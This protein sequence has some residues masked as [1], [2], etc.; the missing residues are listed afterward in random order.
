MG[1]KLKSDILVRL[2]Y[3]NTTFDCLAMMTPPTSRL[4]SISMENDPNQIEVSIA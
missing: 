2:W 1:T 4:Y 3:L